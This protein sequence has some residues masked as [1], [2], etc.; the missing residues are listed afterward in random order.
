MI[1]H[2]YSRTRTR[3][4]T[5]LNTAFCTLELFEDENCEESSGCYEDF[6]MEPEETTTTRSYNYHNKPS[7]RLN[8]R[9][10]ELA[11]EET[12]TMSSL[13]Q[14]QHRQQQQ[15]QRKQR[16]QRQ[17]GDQRRRK[18]MNKASEVKF[19]NPGYGL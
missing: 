18:Q 2:S 4:Y 19:Y 10:Y 1:C 13:P 16:K 8:S 17:R 11:R 14:P 7:K 15:Q 9:K 6:M 3:Q 5:N 12:T